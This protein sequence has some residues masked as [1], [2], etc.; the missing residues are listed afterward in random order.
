[1][2][3]PLSSRVYITGNS[4]SPCPKCV[5]SP[6]ACTY[7]RNVGGACSA[8]ANTLQTSQDCLPIA[9][10]FTAPLAVT[11]NPLSTDSPT[12]T[13]TGGIFCGATQRTAGAFGKAAAQCIQEAGAPG[14]NLLDHNAHASELAAV[15]C[16][17]QTNNPAIDPAADL[18]GP[19][20]FSITGNAQLVPCS[21]P[22]P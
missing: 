5:G 8:G 7:G 22:C 18:P 21:G 6:A 9:S 19:G 12:L 15:F 14:G 13:G 20:A 4:A 16:I 11:L 10:Q 2:S 1:V 3:I 17:P